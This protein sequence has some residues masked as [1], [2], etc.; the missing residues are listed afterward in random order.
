MKRIYFSII[1]EFPNNVIRSQTIEYLYKMKEEKGL[2]FKLIILMSFVPLIKRRKELKKILDDY[3]KNYGIKT[4]IFPVLRNHFIASSYIGFLLFSIFFFKY[5]NY[6]IVI[7]ARGGFASNVCSKLKKI[8]SNL[9]YV[10]DFRGDY[11]AENKFNLQRIKASKLKIKITDYLFPKFLKQSLRNSDKIICVSNKLKKLIIE[12][13]DANS[14]IIFVMP[15]LA[16]E[17]TFYYDEE[18]RKKTR[19][20]LNIEDKFAFIYAGGIGSWRY[21]DAVFQVI[22]D[23]KKK[24]ENIFFI[25]LTPNEKEAQNY[26]KKYFDDKDIFIAKASKN[27]VF[28]Y[29][30]AADMGVLL[31][32]YDPLNIVA[33][34]TKFA[35]YYLTGLPA[36]ISENIGD[37]S[38][39]VQ[40]EN[41]G[42]VLSSSLSQKEYLSK[43]ENYLNKKEKV[44]RS[45]LSCKA[46]N[47]LSKK[48]Y[49]DKLCEIYTTI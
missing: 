8:Y 44:D 9:S 16:D 1:S 18:I 32:E 20:R 24:F 13:Y 29:L 6:K 31:R 43:F 15:C 10:C 42:I 33:S 2:N 35:E 12:K 47:L 23:I 22:S 34:P 38:E 26:S 21:S 45:F 19:R 11:E 14:D 30:N 40:K 37:Y 17:E 5:R 41:I 39:L 36:I 27:E 49:I 7:H 4:I 46:K 3:K 28:E 48:I 25:V